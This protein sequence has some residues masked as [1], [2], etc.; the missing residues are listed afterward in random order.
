MEMLSPANFSGT[1]IEKHQAENNLSK[2]NEGKHY[3]DH[4]NDTRHR[5]RFGICHGVGHAKP[6]AK[7]QQ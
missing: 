1:W 7:K 2:I 4:V 5:G 6:E 3:A